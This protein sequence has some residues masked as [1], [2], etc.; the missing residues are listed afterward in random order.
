MWGNA[1]RNPLKTQDNLPCSDQLYQQFQ[2]VF[3]QHYNSLCN[4]A[5][6]FLKDFEASEDVVQDLFIKIWEKRPDL[7]ATP[8]IR[9]YLFT[10]VRNNC[11]THLSKEKRSPLISSIGHEGIAIPDS[12]VQEHSVEIDYKEQLKKAINQLPPKCR[13]VFLLSRISKLSYQEIADQLSISVKTVENQVGKALKVLRAFAREKH[14]Q[15]LS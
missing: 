2:A 9:F 5:H 6:S 11:L 3:K 14:I 8:T 7:I 4:Y 15:P 13:E 10:S 12:G 1:N